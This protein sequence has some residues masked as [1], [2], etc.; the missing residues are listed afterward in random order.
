MLK[1]IYSFPHSTPVL[2]FQA[3][4]YCEKSHIR[5]LIRAASVATE[6]AQ[7]SVIPG[8]YPES[9]CNARDF[10]PRKADVTASQSR[11]I[12]NGS[13][14]QCEGPVDC[15]LLAWDHYFSFDGQ[16]CGDALLLWLLRGPCSHIGSRATESCASCLPV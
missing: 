1:I 7:Y 9:N 8:A 6:I 3:P 5:F 11:T 14:V 10:L 4:N 12:S 13:A 2:L 15:R 16:T